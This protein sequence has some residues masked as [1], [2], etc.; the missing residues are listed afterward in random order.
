MLVRSV[1]PASLSDGLIV[2]HISA[3]PLCSSHVSQVTR[4][5]EV[6]VSKGYSNSIEWEIP[7][8]MERYEQEGKQAETR[9]QSSSMTAGTGHPAHFAPKLPE[10]S[11]TQSKPSQGSASMSKA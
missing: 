11:I 7:G 4:G 8:L 2:A 6:T 10:T 3:K 5:A 1:G 9:R